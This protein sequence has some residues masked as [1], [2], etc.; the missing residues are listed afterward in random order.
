MSINFQHTRAGE[1]QHTRAGEANS[2]ISKADEAGGGNPHFA[3][4]STPRWMWQTGDEVRF[5]SDAPD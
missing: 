2:S 3:T 5:S 1:F 4:L